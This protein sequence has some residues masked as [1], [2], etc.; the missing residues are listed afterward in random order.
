[1]NAYELDVHLNHLHQVQERAARRVLQMHEVKL[2]R[3]NSRRERSVHLAE[4]LGQLLPR[5][6]RTRLTR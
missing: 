2:V 5:R 6:V 4:Y 3:E 1:M